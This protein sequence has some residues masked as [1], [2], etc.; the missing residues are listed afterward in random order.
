MVKISPISNTYWIENHEIYIWTA[1]GYYSELEF[2]DI[3]TYS[4]GMHV[5]FKYH[6]NIYVHPESD[7]I[8]VVYRIYIRYYLKAYQIYI[9]LAC[10]SHLVHIWVTILWTVH[11]WFTFGSQYCEPNVNGSHYCDRITLLWTVHIWVT[12][13]WTVHIWVTFFFLQIFNKFFLLKFFD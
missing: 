11:I 2:C 7:I 1:C 5:I 12:I 8:L 6:A 9:L 3:R 10:G 13:M 4:V